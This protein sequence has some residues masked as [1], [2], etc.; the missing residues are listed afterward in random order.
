MTFKHTNDSNISI[1]EPLKMFNNRW[2]LLKTMVI[3]AENLIGDDAFKWSMFQS[4]DPHENLHTYVNLTISFS[5]LKRKLRFHVH[6][7][8]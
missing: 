1:S 4:K 3:S 6:R 8:E 7:K 2:Q 5:F